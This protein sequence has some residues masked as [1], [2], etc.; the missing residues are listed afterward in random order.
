MPTI[1][2]RLFLSQLKFIRF[3]ESGWLLGADISLDSNESESNISAFDVIENKINKKV[4]GSLYF[5][6]LLSA[7]EAYCDKILI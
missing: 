1:E 5:M 3:V 2:V 4:I 7:F 6:M